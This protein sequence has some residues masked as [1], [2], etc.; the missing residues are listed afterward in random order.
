MIE[1]QREQ[2]S[3][4]SLYLPIPP[5][6]SVYLATSSYISLAGSTTFQFAGVGGRCPL[7]LGQVGPV[8]PCISLYLPVSP[9]LGGRCPLRLGQV[10]H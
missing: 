2:G 1:R 8:S 7:R 10:R 4:T 3:T 6:I 9:Y 5:Y